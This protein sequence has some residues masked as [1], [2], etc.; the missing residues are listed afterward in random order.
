VLTLKLTGRDLREDYRETGRAGLALT[1]N[2][3]ERIDAMK[4]EKEQK[5]KRLT[6]QI[7]GSGPARPRAPSGTVPAKP[8]ESQSTCGFLSD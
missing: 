8:T 3:D 5:S 7:A 4:K 1:Y 2:L 6:E